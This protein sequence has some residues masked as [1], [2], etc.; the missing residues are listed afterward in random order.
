M[1][2][3]GPSR[4]APPSATSTRSRPTSRSIGQP[5]GTTTTKTGSFGFAGLDILAAGTLAEQM[6]FLLVYTPGLGS[7]AF[8]TQPSD[9]DLESAWVG[10]FRLFGTPFLNLRVGKF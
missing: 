8:G 5:G 6:S 7:A 2:G 3:T 10:F 9:G 1:A 4:C